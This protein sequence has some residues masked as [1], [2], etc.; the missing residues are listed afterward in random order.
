MMIQTVLLP[1]AIGTDRWQPVVSAFRLRP[2]IKIR[3]TKPLP[4][5]MFLPGMEP[6]AEGGEI[7]L[8]PDNASDFRGEPI[9]VAACTQPR[10]PNCGGTEFDEDGDCTSCW[11]PGVIEAGGRP[12]RRK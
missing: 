4:G 2:A 6:A 10:C 11:E 9:T 8:P 1:D 5:Q 7:S 3:R 12:R